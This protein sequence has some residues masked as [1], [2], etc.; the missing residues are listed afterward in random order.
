MCYGCLF[1]TGQGIFCPYICRQKMAF[2]L[3]KYNKMCYHY[4]MNVYL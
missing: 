2:L 1:C 4:K 3:V